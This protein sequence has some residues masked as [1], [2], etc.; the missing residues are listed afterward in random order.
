MTHRRELLTY[1][2]DKNKTP[3]AQRSKLLFFAREE[4]NFL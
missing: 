2:G 1:G 4:P 3:V